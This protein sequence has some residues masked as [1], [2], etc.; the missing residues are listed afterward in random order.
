MLEY[1]IRKGLYLKTSKNIEI[2]PFDI[3]YR[4]EKGDYEKV[5]SIID[6]V[7]GEYGEIEVGDLYE[8]TK[9]IAKKL[10]EELHTEVEVI[11]R[12]NIDYRVRCRLGVCE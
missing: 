3:V 11:G 8:L 4:G 7:F 9:S 2:L 12:Y 6:K 10:C 5:K 1:V